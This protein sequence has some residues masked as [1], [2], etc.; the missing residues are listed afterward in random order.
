MLSYSLSLKG[1]PLGKGFEV[2]PNAYLFKPSKKPKIVVV[3]NETSMSLSTPLQTL[4]E[5]K[6]GKRKAVKKSVPQVPI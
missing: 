6:K 4:I 3:A 5:K 1:I 2:H